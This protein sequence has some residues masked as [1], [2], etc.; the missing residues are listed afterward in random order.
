MNKSLNQIIYIS[1]PSNVSM[2]DE[3][4]DHASL[5]HFWVYHRNIILK[6]YFSHLIK[7]SER[8]GEIGCGNGLILTYLAQAFHKAV[9][10]IDLNLPALQLC[11]TIPGS[12]YVYDIFQ[13]DSKLCGKYD[14]LLLIDVLEHIDQDREF[15][16][17]VCEHLKPGGFLIIGVPMRQ[18]LFSAYDLAAGHCRR[19]SQTR[20]NSV[21][22]ASGLQIIKSIQWGHAYIP[23]LF[24]RK[25]LLRFTKSE[26]TISQGFASI[27]I[28][29]FLLS[30]LRYLDFVPAL[31][32]T[33]TSSF[34]LAQKIIDEDY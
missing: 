26:S 34:L 33:G 25:L 8:I 17:A 12:L 32:I 10:G 16:L 22:K 27:G 13:R 19:Y 3:W 7:S 4:Y 5:D 29:N 28:K 14:L 21:V 24:V 11:P 31:N 23:L 2:A 30:L 18:S 6:K 9:D 1:D 15:L 20:L